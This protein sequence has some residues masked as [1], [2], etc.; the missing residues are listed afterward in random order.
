MT[1]RRS[2][3]VLCAA[4]SAILIFASAS[5]TAQRYDSD[6][7][8][9]LQPL[10]DTLSRDVFIGSTYGRAYHYASGL[11]CLEGGNCVPFEG[12]FGSSVTMIAGADQNV[13]PFWNITASLTMHMWDVLMTVK[14]GA[15]RVRMPDGSIVN[16]IRELS[17]EARG[18][19]FG[20][21][22]GPEYHREGW[23][24]SLSPTFE[25]ALVQPRWTQSATIIEPS[26]IRYPDG[27]TTTVVV[28][29]TNITN[30][31]VFRY[32]L[33]G[34]I[35]RDVD[36]AGILTITPSIGFQVMPSRIRSGADWSD[37]RWFGGVVIRRD[38][39]QLPDTVDRIRTS[40]R[41]DTV[42][43]TRQSEQP[44]TLL[45]A[46]IESIVTD[47]VRN[48]L[49]RQI[50]ID[51][52]R[53]DTL[54]T[55]DPT[56]NQRL[57]EIRKSEER[58]MEAAKRPITTI[59]LGDRTI[60]LR[61]KQ[62]QITV[63]GVDITARVSDSLGGNADITYYITE[64]GD[65]VDYRNR[66]VA[67]EL[68]VRLTAERQDLTFM[69]MPTIFFDSG[70]A[71]MP[72]RYR[73]IPSKFEYKGATENIAQHE[74]NLDILN[75]MG[76]RMDS[77]S[78][79]IIVRG[80]A[81]ES[82]E[83]G[84]CD[85]ARA[86]AVGV[87]SYLTQIW[88]INPE[89]IRI[90]VGT[91]SCSPDPASFGGNPRGRAENRRVEFLSEDY[92]YFMPVEKINFVTKPSWDM[93]KATVNIVDTEDPVSEWEITY[94]QSDRVLE[95]RR[96]LGTF[97]PTTLSLSDQTLDSLNRDPIVVTFHLKT[98]SGNETDAE[99]EIPVDKL[100]RIRK[101]ENLSLAMFAVRSTDLS[102]RDLELLKLFASRL[103]A[104][105][106]VA[107]LG[108][109]DDL[110]NPQRNQQ[111]S[112]RRAESVATLLRSLRPDCVVTRVEGLASTRYPIG[113]DS[114]ELPELRFMSRTVQLVVEKQ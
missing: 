85:L 62:S 75:I 22:I 81:D 1:G 86:R 80:F 98:I 2:I 49:L 71:A 35:G 34:M 33:T 66:Q 21:R 79:T 41:I 76:Q 40:I 52:R 56:L 36:I 4:A 84:S 53:T 51:A 16:L 17:M 68:A 14:D 26:G 23:R 42:F 57:A 69:I 43:A 101:F 58:K 27:T 11:E 55:L 93:S 25:F 88:G 50:T 64:E 90:E 104:G 61:P 31:S 95:A 105:D 113:V 5:M 59:S 9:N 63:G 107:I 32:G 13:L 96:G 10:A 12:G 97:K 91:G 74:V 67:K 82:S 78:E 7:L 15:A 47:T 28:P 19:T 70:S 65:T 109:S 83:G 48:G 29:E 103:D 73:Q 112:Q 77:L 8:W 100:D 72:A 54:I 6:S 108:Y 39:D 30:A 99:L 89:R 38:A 114:Y 3:F 87:V 18:T 60:V 44:G 94:S 37:V 46:G 45:S 20:L 110:G 102:A 24:L 106:R 92:Q 111:L